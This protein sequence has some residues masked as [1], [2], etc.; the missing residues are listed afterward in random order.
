M[1]L[2]KGRSYLDSQ[3]AI[4]T[5]IMMQVP[6]VTIGFQFKFK[7]TKFR[8]KNL[9]A[10]IRI[11]KLEQPKSPSFAIKLFANQQC[12]CPHFVEQGIIHNDP[13]EACHRSKTL[14]LFHEVS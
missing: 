1:L 13:L 14:K 11:F 4:I 3:N 7:Q 8:L 6:A 2:H 12:Q 5:I 10:A 9:K